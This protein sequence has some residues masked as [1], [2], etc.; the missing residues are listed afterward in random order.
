VSATVYLLHFLERIGNPDNPR[1]MAQHYIGHS[2]DA[3]ERIAQHTSG[4]GRAAKIV[5]YVQAQGIGFEVARTWPGDWTLE[6]Q[7]KRRHNAPK[8]C[9]VCREARP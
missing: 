6:R 9:P 1:A 3:P 5:R 4:N 2:F 8:L 7:L